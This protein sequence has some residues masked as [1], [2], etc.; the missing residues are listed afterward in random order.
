MMDV[1]GRDGDAYLV[2]DGP[3]GAIVSRNLPPPTILP[4]AS[5]LA[6]REFDDYSGA[7]PTGLSIGLADRLARARVRFEAGDPVETIK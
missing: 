2:A 4:L 3:V 6:H 7:L 1:V 5:L